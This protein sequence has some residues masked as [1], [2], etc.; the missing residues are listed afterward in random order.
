MS[1]RMRRGVEANY[2]PTKMESGELAV[3]LDTNKV[4]F[5][6]S[7]STKLANAILPVTK[8]AVSSLPVTITTSDDPKAAYI[9]DDM[10]LV[11]FD[12]SNQSAMVGD[13]SY[14]TGNGYVTIS[15]SI[16]GSTSITVRLTNS[17]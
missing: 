3:C 7:N 2:D 12:L 17:R 10:L 1:I 11:G 4:Y 16:S 5:M 6:G 13:W 8:S 9:T 14:T 15:G